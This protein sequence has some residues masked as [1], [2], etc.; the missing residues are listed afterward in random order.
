MK[1]INF[2]IKDFITPIV[3]AVI[4]II[5]AFLGE[6]V[7]SALRYD[8]LGIEQ[9]QYWRLLTPHFVH[10][11]WGHLWL[12]MTGLA[13][14][15]LFFARCIPI[16]LWILTFFVCAIGIS[17]L[18]YYLNPEIRWYVGLSGVLHGLFVIGGI[19]DK[20]NGKGLVLLCSFSAKYCMNNCLVLYRAQNKLPV[21]Q[22]WLMHIFM[23]Q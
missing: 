22:C 11:S 2:A 15:F 19:A 13:L 18:I 23:V 14:V 16:S 6:P 8:S 3:I 21:A 17:V 5:I 1:N 9:H 7:T 10:L 20:E 12:N 4:C